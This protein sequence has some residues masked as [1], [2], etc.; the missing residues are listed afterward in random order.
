MRLYFN[1]NPI[2]NSPRE[3]G[4]RVGGYIYFGP[5]AGGIYPYFVDKKYW[6]HLRH[7]YRE[8]FFKRLV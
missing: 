8:T 5:D 2:Y 6:D 1:I 7:E 3:L 4:K